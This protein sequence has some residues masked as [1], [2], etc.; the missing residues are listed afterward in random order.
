VSSVASDKLPQEV[1]T[2]FEIA[3]SVLTEGNSDSAKAGAMLVKGEYS[4]VEAASRSAGLAPQ[5]LI[6]A[7]TAIPFR[8]ISKRD[9]IAISESHVLVM[10]GLSTYRAEH[11]RGVTLVVDNGR[12]NR[13]RDA[14]YRD[15]LKD[16][17]ALA[18]DRQLACVYVLD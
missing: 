17:L 16:A 11:P 1:E 8:H 12:A 4:I 18:R 15:A 9:E 10:W 6:T 5:V 2:A 13:D 14:Q 3:L 7:D